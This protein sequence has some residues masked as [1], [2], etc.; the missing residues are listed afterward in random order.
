MTHQLNPRLLLGGELV[1]AIAPRLPFNQGQLQAQL[2]GK[3][4]ATKAW[5]LDFAITG[6]RYEAAPRFGAAL[7]F[8]LTF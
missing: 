5:S 8:S 4:Q 7:G 2:G 6:G 1:A 3:F